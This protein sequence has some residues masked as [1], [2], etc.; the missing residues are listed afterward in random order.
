MTIV[1]IVQPKL[2]F[3][4]TSLR[5]SFTLSDFQAAMHAST[6]NA[7]TNY[8]KSLLACKM[9]I[10]VYPHCYQALQ[11]ILVGIYKTHVV[12]PF[13]NT[14]SFVIPEA[15]ATAIKSSGV[16]TSLSSPGMK[17][18]PFDSATTTSLYV[19]EMF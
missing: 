12:V 6:C 7:L 17:C 11:R 13:T 2:R 8:N 14:S 3:K 15:V 10:F 9:G 4:L 16:W 1:W 19:L 18:Q 5:A